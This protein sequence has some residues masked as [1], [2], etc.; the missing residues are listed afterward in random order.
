MKNI[1]KHDGPP[2]N[3]KGG[4]PRGQRGGSNRG[5][6]KGGEIVENVWLYGVH[7]VDAALRNPKR[8]VRQLLATD[9]GMERLD[10][11]ALAQHPDL[12]IRIGKTADLDRM[13]TADSVHQGLLL[14][15][16]P[17]LR[18]EPKDLY[19]FADDQI[20]LVLDQVTDPHNVGAI[21]RSAVA[22][23]VKTVLVTS[24]HQSSE[25]G[26]LAKS[27]SGAVDMVDMLAI[28]NLSKSLDE[29]REHRFAVIG[30]DSE[31]PLEVQ[32]T[33]DDLKPSK[34]AL[35]LGA[36]GKGL[37][38]QTREACTALARLDMPGPIKSLNV[39]NAAAL[40]LYLVRAAIKKA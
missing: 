3:K 10:H 14:D 6:P 29:L 21:L 12:D 35:V 13:V 24:R 28:R 5:G 7:T 38:E 1:R 32:E 31:G 17:L 18:E 25:T 26:V 15:C 40:S 34:V 27:A 11:N 30:L 2:T 4:K 8:K 9:S 33:L 19:D 16:E 39:S 20:I 37:R 22:M 36:E 23:G